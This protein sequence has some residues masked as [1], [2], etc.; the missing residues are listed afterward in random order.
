M[1][2][3]EDKQLEYVNEVL[4]FDTPSDGR[5]LGRIETYV[6]SISAAE[7]KR[8][9]EFESR[10]QMEL[11]EATTVSPDGVFRHS[12]ES[13]FGPLESKTSR[14]ALFFLLSTLNSAFPDCDFTSVKPDMFTRESSAWYAIGEIN[15][16]LSSAGG[17]DIIKESRI[18]EAVDVAV[19]LDECEV[20]SF[21]PSEAF[22][23]YDDEGGS[24]WSLNYFFYNKRMKRLVFFTTRCLSHSAPLQDDE[25][26]VSDEEAYFSDDVHD[27]DE[28]GSDEDTDDEHSHQQLHRYPLSPRMQRAVTRRRSVSTVRSFHEIAI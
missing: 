25:P 10:I 2:Y 4:A 1:K 15:T 20:Y 21:H 24:V 5:V 8:Y 7:R 9:N 11:L 17:K 14:R 18:W 23:P 12:I 22:D 28:H 13:P 6:C 26:T 16:A 19:K 27:A 3:F